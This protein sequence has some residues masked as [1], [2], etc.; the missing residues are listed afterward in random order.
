MTESVDRVVLVGLT[1][2]VGIVSIVG[3]VGCQW[4]GAVKRGREV[5]NGRAE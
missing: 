2:V 3:I 5:G 1:G 4:A